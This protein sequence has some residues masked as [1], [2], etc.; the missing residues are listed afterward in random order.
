MRTLRW[1]AL[2]I[3]LLGVAYLWQSFSIRQS[4]TYSA[5]GPRFFPIAIGIGILLS[6]V[7]LFAAPGQ[8]ATEPDSAQMVPLDWPRLGGM[9]LLIIAYI[10]LFKPAG[11]ILSTA[12]MLLAGSQILGER[13]HLL[14]DGLIGV[15]LALMAYFLFAQLLGI[16]LPKGL[17]GW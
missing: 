12:V 13:K 3:V 17:I 4:L 5:V 15:F 6:G 8:E 2:A 7:W 14:R 11:Y 9:T 1:V 10:L 16:N